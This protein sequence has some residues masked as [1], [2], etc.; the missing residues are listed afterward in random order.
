VVAWFGRIGD[1]LGAVQLIDFLRVDRFSRFSRV[2]P[3]G[4]SAFTLIELLVVIAIIAILAG[5]LLPA[6]SKAKSKAHAIGCVNHLKQLMLIWTMYAGDHN[7]KLVANGRGA[8][9][10]PTWVAG[11]FEGTP[12]DSTNWFLLTDP[13]RSLFAP[14]LKTAEIYRCPA[15]RTME[16]VGGRRQRVVR[17]Y[18]MNALVGW[19]GDTYRENPAPGYRVF[20]R[21]TDFVD[22]GPSETFV[23][24]EIHPKSL[25]RPFFGVIMNA[26]TWYHIPANHHG[27]SSIFS[28]ADGHVASHR[29]QDASTTQPP[30]NLSWHGHS[31]SVRGS[32]DIVWF[33]QH[34]SSRR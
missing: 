14:Y 2:R 7:E 13:S 15:D 19:E 20:G 25:C 27:S 1:S 28:Y 30:D 11:S 23:I 12:A 5:M 33:Q 22:P 31:Y 17:S 16:T 24:A 21:S 6:L 18:G 29:W 26:P 8:T 32:R 9:A 4:R 10:E 34:A 3:A